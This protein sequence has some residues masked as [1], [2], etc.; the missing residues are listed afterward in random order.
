ME[1]IFKKI[2]RRKYE[3]CSEWGNRISIPDWSQSQSKTGIIDVNGHQS[4]IPRK[5]DLLS[6][7]MQKTE[8]II[9]EFIEVNR[10]VDPMDM[11]FAKIKLIDYEKNLTITA[12]GQKEGV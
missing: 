3:I 9:A 8:A 6:I 4:I 5:G 10:C 7:P 1:V 12:C 11:F 2:T